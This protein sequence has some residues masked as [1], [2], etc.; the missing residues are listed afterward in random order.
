MVD[1]L[2]DGQMDGWTG[3][4]VPVCHGAFLEILAFFTWER[5]GGKGSACAGVGGKG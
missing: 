1:G 3:A 2:P 4:V 5:S